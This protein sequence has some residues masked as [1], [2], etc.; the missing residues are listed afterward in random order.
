M[1]VTIIILSMFLAG[2]GLTPEGDAVR[3]AVRDYGARAADAELVNIE[4]AL[5]NGVTVGA[6]AR[7]YGS[8]QKKIDGW[9][10]ICSSEAIAP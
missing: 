5:C 10:A 3:A 4:W 2:C 9:R 6:F 7:R 8:N 1:K